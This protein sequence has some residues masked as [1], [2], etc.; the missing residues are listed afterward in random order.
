MLQHYPDQVK[1][2]DIGLNQCTAQINSGGI[3]V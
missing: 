3:D 2:V 1:Y